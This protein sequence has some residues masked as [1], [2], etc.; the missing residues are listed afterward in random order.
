ME[1]KPMVRCLVTALAI[2]A[3]ATMSHAEAPQFQNGDRVCVV[4]D[5]ITHG[6]RYHLFLEAFYVTRLP[7]RRV[8]FIN[9]GIA[10]DTAAGALRRFDWDIAPQKPTV[11]TILLGMNDVGI[12][13]YGDDKTEEQYGAKRTARIDAYAANMEQLVERLRAIGSK[14]ILLTPTIYDDQVDVERVNYSGANEGLARCAEK[15]RALAK[16]KNVPLVEVFAP[17]N[18]LNAKLLA[19]DPK[20]TVVGPDRVHPLDPGQFFIAWCIMRAQ[21]LPGVV[22]SVS[23]DAKTD[24]PVAVE[25]AELTDYQATGQ[26]IEFTLLE[27][28]LPFPIPK[29]IEPAMAWVPFRQETNR[30]TLKVVGLA[31]DEYDI[32]IDGERLARTTAAELAEG[33]EL[34]DNDKTPMHR[35]AA[36]VYD[37]LADRFNLQVRLRYVAKTRHNILQDVAD[38]LN[39]E[40]AKPALD[41]FLEKRKGKPQE[42]YYQW[43]VKTYVENAPKLD[44]IQ[45]DID[46]LTGEAYDAAQPQPHRFQIRPAKGDAPAAAES[47]PSVL[48]TFDG[49]TEWKPVSITNVDAQFTT[50]NGIATVK[51]P[52]RKG[53]RDLW[54][55]SMTVAADTSAYKTIHFRVKADKGK[56]TTLRVRDGSKLHNTISYVP[57]TGDWQD[58]SGE[59]PEGGAKRVYI[60]LGESGAGDPHD[61]DMATYE[62]DKI[63][64]E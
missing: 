44:E 56:K 31:A 53:E 46:R 15:V 16:E 18:A 27:K 43:V 12:S 47:D 63:W 51:M 7:D 14:V 42:K 36:K 11:S 58:L 29:T 21:N 19:E 17:M 3:A 22:S 45:K 25:N 50:D 9:C 61:A 6:R 60:I 34:A 5:S 1:M 10:G 32:L 26:G 28:S 35:Q 33:I 13:L 39:P 55:V 38:P 40:A 30:E 8:D 4:G 23:I 37:I 64:F 20:A 49:I 52:Q 41:A 48:A 57:G 62:F 2:A 54:C 24:K 59:L